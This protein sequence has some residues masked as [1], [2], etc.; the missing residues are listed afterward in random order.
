[1]MLKDLTSAAIIWVHSKQRVS[2]LEAATQM[3]PVKGQAY[4][5]M[6]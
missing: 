1:M 3:I 5:L 4:E 6:C 2:S